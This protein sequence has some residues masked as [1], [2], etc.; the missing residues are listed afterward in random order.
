[1]EIWLSLKSGAPGY[2]KLTWL[3]PANPVE[4]G[5]WAATN[6]KKTNVL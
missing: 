4:N 6:T 1:M 2:N 3:E 5:T